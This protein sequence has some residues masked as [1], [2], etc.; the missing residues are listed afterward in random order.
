[1]NQETVGEMMFRSVARTLALMVVLNIPV[2]M[3]FLVA[4]QVSEELAMP[5]LVDLSYR[6]VY[7]VMFILSQ[8]VV[9]GVRSV[10]NPVR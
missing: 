5:R 6:S 7:I 2:G 8:I 9:S 10:T 1:M 3:W 4:S